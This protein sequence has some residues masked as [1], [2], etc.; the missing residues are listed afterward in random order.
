MNMK[1]PIFYTAIIT[2]AASMPARAQ[3]VSAYFG[4]G[5]AY[6]TSTGGRID[7]F[8]DGTIY[9]TPVLDGAFGHFGGDVFLRKT[10]AVGGEISWRPTEGDYAGIQ[11][12]PTLYSVDA[13]YRPKFRKGRWEPELR[14]GLGGARIHF[15]PND[16]ASCA[17]VPG[18]PASDHFQQHAAAAARW[19]FSDHF[20]LRPAIDIHHVDHLYEFG[21]NWV[22]EF[23]IGIGYSVGRSE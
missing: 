9:K 1:L 17:Q 2:I 16:D 3:E 19:Y 13:I 6:A 5:S 22:P 12:R 21:A 11:Y 15:F 20:F 4:V 14:L 10:F 18:C 23:S 7:T 8:G